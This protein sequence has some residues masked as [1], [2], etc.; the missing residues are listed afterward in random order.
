M[1]KKLLS[2][3]I[4]SV[5]YIT[6][7]AQELDIDQFYDH[8]PYNKITNLTP[9][10]DKLYAATPHGMFIYNH[11]DNSIERFSKVEGLSDV[12]VSWI[13][14]STDHKTLVVAYKNANIDL[15]KE[16]QVINI[17]DIR[18]ANILGNKT[19]NRIFIKGKFAYL[20]C[21]F[22]IVVVDI[23]REEI[24][25][26]YRIGP[27]G[28]YLN[29]YDFAY[30]EAD[31]HFYAATELGVFSADADSPNLAHY[32]HWE[33]DENLPLDD[34]KINAL[35]SHG[36]YIL[37]NKSVTQ[38][39]RDTIYYKAAQEGT[40]SMLESDNNT[41]VSSFRTFGDYLY[42]NHAFAMSIFDKDLNFES[43]IYT[44]G[45]N[46]GPAPNDVWLDSDSVFWV[47][48]NRKGLVKTLGNM[49]SFFIQPSGPEHVT[50]FDMATRDGEVW[51]ASGGFQS[52]W[53]GSF[54]RDGLSHY[55]DEEWYTY[56]DDIIDALDSIP[57]IVSVAIDPGTE[58]RVYAG[59]W[60]KGL[61]ELT[62]GELTQIYNKS[63]S[64]LQGNVA[65]PKMIQISGLAFDS[66]QNLWVVNNG[67]DEVLSMKN[68]NGEWMSYGLGS[69]SSGEQYKNIIIDDYD[70][71][72]IVMRDHRILVFNHN[73]TLEDQTDD[74][75]KVLTS[76]AG[77]GAI[78][79]ENAVH[80]IAKDLNGN[81][82]IGTDEGVGVVYN[83]E[84]VFTGNNFDA[85]KPKVEIDGYVEY[86]LSSEAVTAIAV[87]GA[88]RKWFGTERGGLFLMS[89][90][91]TDQI[92]HFTETNS[93][94]FSNHIT[95]LAISETG[96]VFIGT[97]N[98]IISYKGSAT[99]G[100]E[101]NKDIFIYPNPVTSQYSGPIAI[102]NLV[103]DAN[104]KITDINGN[105]VYETFAEGGNAQWNGR[106][107]DGQKVQTGYYMVF[108]SNDDG[109][110]TIV[111]KILMIR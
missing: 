45:E 109:T 90:D 78:P 15:V 108:V 23:E 89:A 100:R 54:L 14:Y 64:S 40:W 104:V 28:S 30:H 12:E 84:D 88:N 52:D 92:K 60:N 16:G 8:L 107:F 9:A 77:N 55:A 82:W 91:G 49:D 73:E 44:Y 86:L 69:A 25:D 22:G 98:G 37:A 53:S 57:D 70:Q 29:V 99:P 2:L 94:I 110:E 56:D 31:N 1:G 67:A 18:R 39:G 80:S 68:P 13:S 50:S 61:I 11:E 71:K 75:A 42:V 47:A 6:G 4:L 76:S 27:D 65:A 5:I 74:F 51:V 102:R 83:P 81:V 17:S 10:E 66:N 63:N 24:H 105:M 101:N 96:M 59:S 36:D 38:Y 103:Q 48:D 7:T 85:V 41:T 46:E 72:W 3:A 33:Q 87:D 93:P 20:S 62:N 111:S 35:I 32:I 26:T 106:N 58:N 79:G 34:E 97:P 19:I 21:G 95:S 43:K